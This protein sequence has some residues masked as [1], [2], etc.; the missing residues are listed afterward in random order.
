MN[1][2]SWKRLSFICRPLIKNQALQN[3]ADNNNKEQKENGV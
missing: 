3:K 1:Q 2:K